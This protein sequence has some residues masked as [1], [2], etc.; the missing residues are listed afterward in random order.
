MLRDMMF[1]RNKVLSLDEIDK[2]F[3]FLQKDS[4]ITVSQIADN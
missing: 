1:K 2:K 3:E 4:R